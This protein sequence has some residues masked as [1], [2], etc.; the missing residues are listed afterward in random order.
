M[1]GACLKGRIFF[2]KLILDEVHAETRMAQIKKYLCSGLKP[3]IA[4]P[5]TN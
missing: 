2:K 4:D 3:P 1:T 5:L